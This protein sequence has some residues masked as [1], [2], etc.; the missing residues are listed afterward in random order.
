MEL[1]IAQEKAAVQAQL[2]RSKQSGSKWLPLLPD[3]KALDAL[4]KLADSEETRLSKIDAETLASGADA[5][6]Q[7]LAKLEAG[8]LD[9]AQASLDEAQKLWSQHVLLASLK[10]SLKKAQA[11]AAAQAKAAQNPSG[12]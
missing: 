9:G 3:A 7:A 4:S 10:E 1:G 2:D 11:E 12:S 5:A 6:R 8:D